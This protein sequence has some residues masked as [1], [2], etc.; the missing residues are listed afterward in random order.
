[1]G[2]T[3]QCVIFVEIIYLIEHGMCSSYD[4]YCIRLE[5]YNYITEAM[6]SHR[7]F[8]S[9]KSVTQVMTIFLQGLVKLVTIDNK[10]LWDTNI[11]R[12][13]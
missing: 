9:P 5:N 1:M 3:V 4:A 2:S 12:K 8:L 10:K 13:A 6:R 11:K 7:Q